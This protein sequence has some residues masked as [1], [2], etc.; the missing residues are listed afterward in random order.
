MN[1]ILYMG[2]TPNGFIAKPNG[3]SEWTSEED[4]AGFYE[5]S[6]KVGNIVLGKNTFDELQ[7]NNQFPFPEV[8]NVVMTHQSIENHWVIKW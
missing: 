4:L 1:V 5:Q 2:I 8:L 3:D 6:K 7:K